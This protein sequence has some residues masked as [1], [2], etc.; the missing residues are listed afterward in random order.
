MTLSAKPSYK[1]DYSEAH[2]FVSLLFHDDRNS[3][4]ALSHKSNYWQDRLLSAPRIAQSLKDFTCCSADSYYLSHNGFTSTRTRSNANCRQISSLMFDIDLHQCELDRLHAR[5]NEVYEVIVNA[6]D[7]QYIPKP[8]VIVNSGRGFQLYY[9]LDRS[10]PCIDGSE[11]TVAYF[12]AIHD[13]ISARLDRICTVF[14]FDVCNDKTVKDLARVGR[15]P[16]TIN[17]HTHTFARIAYSVEKFYTLSDLAGVVKEDMRRSKP[18]HSYSRTITSRAQFNFLNRLRSLQASRDY[19]SDGS[20][21]LMCFVFYNTSV[22]AFSSREYCQQLV[23]EFN[24]CFAKPLEDSEIV[25]IINSVDSN[26]NVKGDVG[27]YLLST[28]TIRNYLNLTPMEYMELFASARER[29]RVEAK[30]ATRE[31]R[32]RRNKLIV[33]L[34]ATGR[35]TQAQL[36]EV[37][38]EQYSI[39]VSVRTI[40]SVLKPSIASERTQSAK[41]CTNSLVVSLRSYERLK[42]LIVG[43]LP[44]Y[45]C[46]PRFSSQNPS[47]ERVPFWDVD[48][49]KHDLKLVIVYMSTI[50]NTATATSLLF[51]WF[52][53]S[54]FIPSFRYSYKHQMKGII[55]STFR[56]SHGTLIKQDNEWVLSKDDPYETVAFNNYTTAHCFYELNDPRSRFRQLLIEVDDQNDLIDFGFFA[57]LLVLDDY[58]SIIDRCFFGW[59]YDNEA[60]WDRCGKGVYVVRDADDNELRR[61]ICMSKS[62]LDDVFDFACAQSPYPESLSINYIR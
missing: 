57:E 62:D 23:Y 35:Y 18:R 1:L 42:S 34:Y 2:K 50:Y 4:Y 26:I 36:A 49:N 54:G 59:T 30:K 53:P 44:D 60:A 5:L 40:K 13:A 47:S 3:F 19:L 17:P 22:Q 8:T 7:A 21:E 37:L 52:Y 58:D 43:N 61:F 51:L 46:V 16:G 12:N 29:K 32:D 28:D 11:R 25:N 20:R 14:D 31:N 38:R 41:K 39:S 6:I 10:I 9:V 15:L 45:F 27:Y 56:V 48:E 33:K 55:M 24:Q